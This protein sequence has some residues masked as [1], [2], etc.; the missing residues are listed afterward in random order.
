MRASCSYNRKPRTLC[1]TL[2]AIFDIGWLT[3]ILLGINL[4]CF[5]YEMSMP[6]GKRH[7]AWYMLCASSLKMN[8]V[9]RIVTSAFFHIGIFH[10]FMNMTTLVALSPVLEKHHG[11]VKY[12]LLNFIL[13]IGQGCLCFLMMHG[14]TYVP[15]KYNGIGSTY[16]ICTV[17]YSGVLSGYTL[18]WSFIGDEEVDVCGVVKIRKVF[19]PW[20]C[21][22]VV[23]VIIPNVSFIG[24]LSGILFACIMR[25][26]LFT[27]D[28]KICGD[29]EY[30][31]AKFIN[32][33]RRR[34][35]SYSRFHDSDMK[36]MR[37]GSSLKEI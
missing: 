16:S 31:Y 22:I 2:E 34:K 5:V 4:G 36:G 29:E 30:I 14:M 32:F 27:K 24:H 35:S 33:I 18:F 3:T 15:V 20:V 23:Q 12:L 6:P 25:F 17:G 21:L 13:I 9:Y 28:E 26:T 1:Q 10:I 11:F 37:V 7:H 8:E 19:F